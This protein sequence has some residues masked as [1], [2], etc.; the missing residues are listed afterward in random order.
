MQKPKVIAVVGPTASGKSALGAYLA[1]KLGGEI[2]SADSRQVYRGMSVISRADPGHLVGIADPR[3][4]F[5]AGQYVR[6]AEKKIIMIYHNKKIPVVVGG[7]GFYA[8][9][10]LGRMP[11]PRAA[12]DR[13]LR[14][15]LN[16]KTLAQLL[17]QLRRIDRKSAARVDPKN[18][19]RIIRA[20]EI[21]KTLGKVPAQNYKPT[22]E[23]LWLGLREPK[24]LKAGVEARLRRGMAAE[25]KRLR[26]RLSSK[27]YRELGFEFSFLADY[28]DKKISKTHLVEAMANGERKYARRQ[29]RWFKRNPCNH[30]V[31]GKA[32]ALRHA[33]SFLSR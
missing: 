21:A 9:A 12:P 32:H 7:T 10:L 11:L 5:S 14:A 25:A 31:D 17:S 3:R 1:Q 24:N 4:Q 23:V 19:V 15:K 22:Y 6:E 33:K 27:R 30:W 8:D 13:A 18:K 29:H 26:A 20:I 28:L 2:I 16:K